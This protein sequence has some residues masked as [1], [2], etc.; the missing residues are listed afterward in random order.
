MTRPQIVHALPSAEQHTQREGTPT[1]HYWQSVR[2][3]GEVS[4][5]RPVRGSYAQR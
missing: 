1:S 2:P 5:S 4:P 3:A